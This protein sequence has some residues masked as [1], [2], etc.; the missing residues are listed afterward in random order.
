[1]RRNH[2][3]NLTL[4]I[5]TT[6]I[7]SVMLRVIVV[8]EMSEVQERAQWESLASVSEVRTLEPYMYLVRC[9]IYISN[10]NGVRKKNHV[11]SLKCK[12]NVFRK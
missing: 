6:L 5:I 12:A 7:S 2:I 9:H 8:I 3:E 10:V 11:S 1:M 4:S